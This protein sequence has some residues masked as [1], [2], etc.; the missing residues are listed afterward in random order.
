[1]P[2]V[3]RAPRA[4]AFDA[5]MGRVYTANHQDATVSVVDI[6]SRTVMAAPRLAVGHRPIAVAIDPANHTVYVANSLDNTLS[7]LTG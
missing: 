1:M 6:G 3:G 7:V 5:S 4:I 2:G